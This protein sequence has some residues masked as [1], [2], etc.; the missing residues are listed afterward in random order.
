MPTAVDRA[1]GEEPEPTLVRRESV[2]VR[3]RR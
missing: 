2:F 1:M 3:R